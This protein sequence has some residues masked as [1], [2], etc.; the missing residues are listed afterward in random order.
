MKKL[1][2][3]TLLIPLF[4]IVSC[5][6]NSFTQISAVEAKQMMD[7]DS[8][9]ILVDVRTQE[10]YDEIHIPDA[11]LLPLDQ[12]SSRAA[13]VIPDKDATYLIYCRSGN[14]SN[15]ASQLLVD[16]GYTNVY[17]MGGIIYWNYETVS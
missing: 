3:L 4:F 13:V 15:Q 2:L 6:T 5:G 7:E 16:M 10:E 1:L 9:I 11:L 17:D 8:S 14:R 12:I